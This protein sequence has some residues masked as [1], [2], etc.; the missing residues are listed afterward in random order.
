MLNV[1]CRESSVG[2][3][4]SATANPP[5]HRGFEGQY[6]ACIC[7]RPSLVILGS[8]MHGLCDMSTY[9]YFGKMGVSENM[10]PYYSSLHSRILITRTPK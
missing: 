5:L 1:F 7:A 10:G 4:E 8:R 6:Q 9:G 2:M 3:A